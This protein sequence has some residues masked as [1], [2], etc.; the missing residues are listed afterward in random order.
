MAPA[1]F[2][3]KGNP[4][5]AAP[6]WS[7]TGYVEYELPLYRWGS[8]IPSFNTSY[9]SR[10]YLDPQQEALISQEPFW[11][12]GARLA[13]RTPGGAIEVAAWVKNLLDQRYK[14]DSFDLSLQF[15]QI[16]EVWAEPRTFGVTISYAF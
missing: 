6:E 1:P 8:L 7:F 4:L 12:F 16:N 14:I 3:Y 11:L 13:Y 2:N 5:I 9:K 15:S 10:T